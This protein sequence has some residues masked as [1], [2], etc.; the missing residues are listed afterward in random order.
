MK[1]KQHKN[2]LFDFTI[3]ICINIY[4]AFLQNKSLSLLRRPLFVCS[5]IITCTET[6]DRETHFKRED[7]KKQDWSQRES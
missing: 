1:T 4:E 6:E 7:V 3:T 5:S 2:I